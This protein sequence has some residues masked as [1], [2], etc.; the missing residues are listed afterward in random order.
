MHVAEKPSIAS[1]VA[2]ALSSRGASGYNDTRTIGTPVHEFTSVNPTF[3]YAPK[4]R[5]TCHK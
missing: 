2:K 1:S 3:T 5:N 4:A